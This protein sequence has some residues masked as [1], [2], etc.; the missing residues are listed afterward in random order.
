MRRSAQTLEGGIIYASNPSNRHLLCDLGSRDLRLHLLQQ[1]R[2]IKRALPSQLR[3][4]PHERK[5]Q[6]FSAVDWR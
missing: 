4:I 5:A 3:A 2:T 1:E 6:I